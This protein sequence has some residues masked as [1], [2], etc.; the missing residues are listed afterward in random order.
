[1]SEK[2]RSSHIKEGKVL[3]SSWESYLSC[4]CSTL[5]SWMTKLR[6]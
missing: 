5:A 3:T 1:L 2:S 6:L 4:L